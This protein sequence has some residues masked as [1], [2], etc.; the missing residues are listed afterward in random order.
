MLHPMSFQNYDSLFF[1]TLTNASETLLL[2]NFITSQDVEM[3]KLTNL[4]TKK[5][6]FFF[7]SLEQIQSSYFNF[8]QEKENIKESIAAS[9]P[10]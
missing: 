8:M 5:M 3:A 4:I 2:L 6:N 7:P 10:R 9:K 1:L